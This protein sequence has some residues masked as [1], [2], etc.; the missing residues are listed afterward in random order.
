[1]PFLLIWPLAQP[2]LFLSMKRSCLRK[3]RMVTRPLRDSPKCCTG[4]MQGVG[5]A[6]VKAG[7]AA[8][9]AAFAKDGGVPLV[10]VAWL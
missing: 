9:G 2:T 8:T 10:H 3:A 5:G 7:V 6:G 4:V 1:M